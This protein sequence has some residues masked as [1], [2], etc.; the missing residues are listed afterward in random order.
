MGRLRAFAICTH[1]KRHTTSHIAQH[2]FH[3]TPS[4]SMIEGLPLEGKGKGH[5]YPDPHDEQQHLAR[6]ASFPRVHLLLHCINRGPPPLPPQGSS[7]DMRRIVV[8]AARL[9]HL[10]YL[11]SYLG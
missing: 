10:G 2:D 8:L 4:A 3:T 7:G 6:K 9:A 11:H 1:N 5:H